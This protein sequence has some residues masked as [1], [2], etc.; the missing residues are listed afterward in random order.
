MNGLEA[1]NMRKQLVIIG[2]VLFFVCVSLTGCEQVSNTLNPEENKFIGTWQ[3]TTL[4]LTI[5]LSLFSDGTCTYLSI[6]GTWD[7]KDGKFVMEFADSSLSSTYTYRFFDN[8]RTLSLTS[9]YG[10]TTIYTKQ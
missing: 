5:S 8:D 2:F 10:L 9:Q 7:I 3:N 1:R 4:G 6:S